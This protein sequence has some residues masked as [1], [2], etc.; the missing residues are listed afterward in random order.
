MNCINCT[1]SL[2]WLFPL[3]RSHLFSEKLHLH[4]DKFLGFCPIKPWLCHFAHFLLVFH[5]RHV[6][7]KK[8][9]LLIFNFGI[10]CCKHEFC[11]Y[12]CPYFARIFAKNAPVFRPYFYKNEPVWRISHTAL[13]SPR[14]SGEAV[15]KRQAGNYWRLSRLEALLTNTSKWGKTLKPLIFEME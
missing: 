9:V 10:F 6:L 2:E 1:V 13:G 7:T 11:P 4:W 15:A 3:K 14:I 5:W 12:F 8:R